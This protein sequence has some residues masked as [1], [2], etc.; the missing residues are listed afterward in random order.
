MSVYEKNLRRRL[1]LEDL[2]RA[3]E[4]RD[5]GTMLGFYAEDARV[6]VLNGDAPQSPPFELRGRA[7]I[8]GYL[9]AICDGDATRRVENGISGEEQISF[10]ETCEYPDGTRILVKTTLD[11]REGEIL[12]Q[13]DVVVREAREEAV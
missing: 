13:V 11:L 4:L 3:V 1:D 2:R 8:A 7:Q 10:S 6:R 5:L 12:R 9:H